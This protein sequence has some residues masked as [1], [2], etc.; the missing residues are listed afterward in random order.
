VG[1]TNWQEDQ[2]SQ[3]PHCLWMSSP[4][5]THTTDNPGSLSKMGVWP[6]NPG[7][8]TK[9]MMA[10]SKETSCEGHLPIV[11]AT[12]MQVVTKLL[13]NLSIS[14]NDPDQELTEDQTP[15]NVTHLS[16]ASSTI[17]NW[18]SAI[19]QPIQ[20]L[21]ETQLVYLVSPH[22]ISTTLGMQHDTLQAVYPIK[23][24]DAL[25]IIPKTKK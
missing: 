17:S 21:S 24:S 8:V 6:F 14:N 7:V 3:F 2:Q 10:P 1:V 9:M 20:Q 4:S 13:R 5:S 15:S 19:N 18:I 12:P 22:P 23:P 16:S 25:A 11:P